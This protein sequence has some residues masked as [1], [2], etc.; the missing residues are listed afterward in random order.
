[1]WRARK[2]RAAARALV[3]AALW[4]TVTGRPL[5]RRSLALS[6]DE[7]P[8]VLYGWGKV[9]R[10]QHL[11][12][13]GPHIS[14]CFLYIR[15]DGSVGCEDDHNKRSLLEF[16]A[17]ALKTIAIKDVESVQYLCMGPD[18]KIRGQTHYSEEDCSFREELDCLGFNQYESPKHHLHII[19]IRAKAK[20][21]LRDQKPSN[22]L[23]VFPRSFLEAKEQLESEVLPRSMESDSMDPFG[24]VEDGEVV[25][26]PSFQK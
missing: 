5:A 7:G 1:M 22:F 20:Q 3:L 12:A 14:N 2:G 18:G 23:P 19:L 8:L 6:D 4:L 17:V 24:M 10:L 21:Q 16:R 15:S 25:K 11:Y 13:A 9:T 26:S